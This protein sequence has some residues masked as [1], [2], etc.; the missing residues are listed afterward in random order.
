M[1]A[2]APWWKHP[3]CRQPAFYLSVFFLVSVVT[4]AIAGPFLTGYGFDEISGQQF[5]PPE[6]A[7]WCGTDIHGRD[8]LTRL[9]W[10]A[11]ISLMVGLIGALVSLSIGVTYGA[12]AGY[13]GGSIDNGM[14]RV[15]DILYSLPRLVFV[16]VLMAALERP[17]AHWIAAVGLQY[18]IP[19]A[20]LLLLFIGLGFVE[21]LTMARIVRG[22]V[23]VLKEQSFVQAALAL[24]QSHTAVLWRHLRPNLTG[25]IL[26]YLTLTIPVIILEESFL[27]F[28][29]LGVQ[30]PLS[31]WGS[32]IS[33]GAQFINPIKIDWWLIA[34]PGGLMALTLLA[35]NFLGDSL[36]D[37][38]DPRS[39]K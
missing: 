15:V 20:R 26:V 28:L 8:L 14:M 4:A 36:R 9:L 2:H 34:F 37:A 35:L 32:L 12:I 3:S 19:D 10:G 6:S 31:S 33:S 1:N 39:K 29:G 21:W 11:R 17:S 18:L 22:Q 24:G 23:L 30:A 7:H 38:L 13:V 27:S 25:I 5:A 16:I